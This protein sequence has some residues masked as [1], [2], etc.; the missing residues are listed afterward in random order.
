MAQYR[1]ILLFT[2]PDDAAALKAAQAAAKAGNAK[3]DRLTT[4][5]ETWSGVVETEE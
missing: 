5:K 2:A 4:R 3:I 1:A